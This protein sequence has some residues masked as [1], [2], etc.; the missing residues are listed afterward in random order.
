MKIGHIWA[1]QHYKGLK[2]Y[3][4]KLWLGFVH[5]CKIKKKN[6]NFDGSN[7]NLYTDGEQKPLIKHKNDHFIVAQDFSA[8]I[9]NQLFTYGCD[10][11]GPKCFVYGWAISPLVHGFTCS[12]HNLVCWRSWLYTCLV[13]TFSFVTY[14]QVMLL[15]LRSACYRASMPVHMLNKSLNPNNAVTDLINALSDNSSVNTTQHTTLEEAVF[16]VSALTSQQWIMITWHV[17]SIV[18]WMRQ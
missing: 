8:R 6:D 10:P 17:F 3:N 7:W 2:K 1:L 16:S 14:A 18:Q 11:R 15:R 12:F 9:G 4:A 5:N 13:I